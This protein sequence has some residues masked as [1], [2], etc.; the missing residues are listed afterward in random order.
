MASSL[1]HC[2]AHLWPRWGQGTGVCPPLPLGHHAGCVEKLL[3]LKGLYN[4]KVGIGGKNGQCQDH[5]PVW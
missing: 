2:H 1:S 3:S 5:G 4:E